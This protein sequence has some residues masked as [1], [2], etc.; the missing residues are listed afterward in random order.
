[1]A[2]AYA[3]LVRHRASNSESF[4]IDASAMDR[5]STTI[6]PPPAAAAVATGPADHR[7]RIGCRGGPDGQP[8]PPRRRPRPR[9]GRRDHRRRRRRGPRSPSRS[10]RRRA[11]SA[12]AP[13]ARNSARRPMSGRAR[14]SGIGPGSGVDVPHPPHPDDDRRRDDDADRRRRHGT[15]SSSSSP[16]FLLGMS[17]RGVGGAPLDGPTAEDAM[18]RNGAAFARRRRTMVSEYSR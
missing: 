11:R 4:G 13:S 1:M 6:P 18:E 12:R 15:S 5:N 10:R 9:A 3:R 7:R 8:H 17:Y 16:S 2:H 14:S